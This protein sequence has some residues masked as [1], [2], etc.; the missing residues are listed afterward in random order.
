MK[1]HQ[2]KLWLG[3]FLMALLTPLGLMLPAYFGAG[4]AWGGWSA[5]ALRLMLGYVPEGLD[6]NADWW[7]A[8]L[9][10]YS[11]AST[12]SGGL[13]LTLYIASALVGA[14]AVGLATYALARR[15]HRHEP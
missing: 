14:L 12:P 7:P 2:K 8:P 6:R 15:L 1:A 11:L 9:P 5:E 4:D 13:Q 3:L 10:D